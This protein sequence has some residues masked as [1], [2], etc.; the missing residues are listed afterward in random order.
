MANTINNKFIVN[1]SDLYLFIRIVE[2]G[3]ITEAA[4]QLSIT[5]PAV[6]FTL[7]RL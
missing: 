7:R 5:P 4:K 2:T 1:I 3:R 6:S